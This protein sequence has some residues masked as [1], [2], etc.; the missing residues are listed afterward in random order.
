ML[1]AKLA[2][3][4]VCSDN[5]ATPA[6]AMPRRPLLPAPASEHVMQ[7]LYCSR[8]ARAMDGQNLA[9]LVAKAARYNAQHRISGILLAGCGLYLQFL[10]GPLS[11]VIVRAIRA[12]L[13]ILLSSI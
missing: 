2:R 11:E 10:E 6:H 12:V 8:K 7:L 1:R 5:G 9:D 3:H 4:R 13:L